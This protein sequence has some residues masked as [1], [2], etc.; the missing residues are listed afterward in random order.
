M[1]RIV[2]YK[3]SN[4]CTLK[5]IG[6]VWCEGVKGSNATGRARGSGTVGE[7]GCW[8]RGIKDGRAVVG[9]GFLRR[10]MDAERGESTHR[11]S[12]LLP[13]LVQI[14]NRML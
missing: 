9:G 10:R 13:K 6:I 7:D 1:N 12:R 2:I 5:I 11:L 4:T 3:K 14:I 8:R